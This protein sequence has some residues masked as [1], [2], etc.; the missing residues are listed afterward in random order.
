M[1]NDDIAREVRVPAS[2]PAY[3]KLRKSFKDPVSLEIFD[4]L[5]SSATYDFMGDKYEF[6]LWK[7]ISELFFLTEDY[8]LTYP[9]GITEEDA[10]VLDCGAY[11]GDSIIPI[12]A[13]LS[14]NRIYWHA[15]EP[16]H[17]NYEK[18]VSSQDFNNYLCEL[19]V[20]ECGVGENNEKLAFV[21]NE[22][23]SDGCR[24]SYDDNEESTLTLEI[25]KIDDMN[26]DVHG[27]LYIKMDIEGSELQALKGAEK[28]I[29]TNR[30]YL[31]IC[32]YHRKNDLLNI[33]NYLMSICDNYNW[34]LRGGC[35]TI[36]WGIPKE[37]DCFNC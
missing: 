2:N 10:T 4:K 13:K 24:F 3:S 5:V 11:I 27:N 17:Q 15:F 6:V 29:S 25:K 28:T 26:I 14:E 22:N 8:W 9:F 33:P 12:A 23:R 1:V 20:Y 35:H 19:H 31:A 32:L 37:K 30:P 18:I 34:Y 36:L 16:E 7:D 21:Y